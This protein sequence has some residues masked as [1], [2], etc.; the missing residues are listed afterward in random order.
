MP[1]RR[2]TDPPSKVTINLPSTLLSKVN[3][4]LFDP[5]RGK[6]HY[7]GLSALITRLLVNW[8][9]DQQKESKDDD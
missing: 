2:H 3:I 7:G 9:K 1:R 4:L 6:R 8:V 5:I